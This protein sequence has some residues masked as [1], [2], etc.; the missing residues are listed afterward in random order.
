[1]GCAS[2][3]DSSGPGARGK[4]DKRLLDAGLDSEF[5]YIKL[6]G[7]GGTGE[8][9]LYRE[10]KSGQ[11]VAI[12]LVPRPLPRV[13]HES[14]LREITV[15]LARTRTTRPHVLCLS[16]MLP[17]SMCKVSAPEPLPSRREVALICS[18]TA[19]RTPPLK[20]QARSVPDPDHSR[21]TTCCVHANSATLSEAD[22]WLL[23]MSRR[24]CRLKIL[25]NLRRA[26]MTSPWH[27]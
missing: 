25:L 14:I 2:S 22:D 17:R 24:R 23:R 6:L 26:A 1:M 7:K 11:L 19:F 8:T 9:H 21:L 10:R 5:E 27:A 4:A 12:K 15:R 13:L 3:K 18:L 20:Q 16:L